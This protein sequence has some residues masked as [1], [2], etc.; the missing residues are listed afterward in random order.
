[1]RTTLTLDDDLAVL[2]RQEA[3]T[4][5]LPFRT[6]VNDALRRGLEAPG[7]R[8]DFDIPPPIAMGPPLVDLTKALSLADEDFA[9]FP[10][11]P[12]STP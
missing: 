8:E 6:V 3:E 1:V 11:S 4:T 9:L 5:G 2:L 7:P 10:G 12:G